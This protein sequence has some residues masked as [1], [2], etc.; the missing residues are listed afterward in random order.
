MHLWVEESTNF[1]DIRK[2]SMKK[3]ATNSQPRS[4]YRGW[5]ASFADAEGVTLSTLFDLALRS[6][7]R[8]KEFSAPPSRIVKRGQ[9][10]KA[11][12]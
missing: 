8:E 7:A 5:I 9:R 10:S 12:K 3:T 1:R 6:Y 2:E 4:A 11:A